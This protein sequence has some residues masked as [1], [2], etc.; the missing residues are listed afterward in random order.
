MKAE[1]VAKRLQEQTALKQPILFGTL[2]AVALSEI[3]SGVGEDDVFAAMS[4]A[5]EHYMA[6]KPKFSIHYGAEAFYGQ[7]M[8]KDPNGWPWKKGLEPKIVRPS[9]PNEFLAERSRVMGNA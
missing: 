6:S 1:L 7:G 5:W 3:S 9:E 8:W 4:S 2:R